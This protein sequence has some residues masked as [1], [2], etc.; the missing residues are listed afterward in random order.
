M[1]P[2]TLAELHLRQATL[3]HRAERLRQQWRNA[4][5]TSALAETV[6]VGKEVKSLQARAD[7]YAS[8]L[9]IAEETT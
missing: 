3:A 6:A 2:L 8:L 1:T 4:P 5:I 7:E 9:R